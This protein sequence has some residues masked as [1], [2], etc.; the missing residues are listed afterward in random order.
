LHL[1]NVSDPVLHYGLM[2]TKFMHI[3]MPSTDVL[4]QLC[5]H[6]NCR[7]QV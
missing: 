3:A 7:I 2:P 5:L 4:M 1:S 6:F